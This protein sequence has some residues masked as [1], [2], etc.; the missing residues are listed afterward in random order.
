MSH[1]AYDLYEPE[2]QA[3]PLVFDSPHSGSWFPADMGAVLPEA[4]LLRGRDAYIDELYGSAPAQGAPLLAARFGRAYI[5]ANRAPEDLDPAMVEGA[6]PRPL[7]ASP[8]AARGVGL[9]WSLI[10]GREAIYD[11]KLTPAEVE[12]RIAGYWRPYHD[13][14]KRLLEEAQARHGAVW[15]IDC[16]SMPSQGDPTTEDGT[17]ARPEIILGDRDGT[18]CEPALT[19]RVAEVFESLGYEVVLNWP[20]KGVE[21]VRRYSAPAEGRH[22]LQ[23]EINRAL[24]C[25]ESSFE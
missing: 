7:T 23:I 14:L 15:H 22:S 1:P 10:E 19:R 17:V 21:L 2:G 13:A 24:Y 3:L 25:D 12:A 18:T 4:T 11:R 6:W 20:Y 8:K 5:D 9:I 16:H